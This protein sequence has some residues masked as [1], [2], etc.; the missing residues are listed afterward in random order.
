[1]GEK[2]FE[3]LKTENYEKW[4][5]KIKDQKTQSRIMNRLDSVK[6]GYFGDF[7]SVDEGVL[8]LRFHFGAGYRI[9][10]TVRKRQIIILL[11]GGHKT[12]Q[13]QDIELAHKLAKNIED[14]G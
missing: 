11:A 6:D 12:K 7:K 9:Y 5:K 13:S 3:I 8:E 10:F 4:F 14:N 1:M 2:M